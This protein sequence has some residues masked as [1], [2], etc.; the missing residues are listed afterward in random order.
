MGENPTKEVLTMNR[1][2]Q[3]PGRILAIALVIAAIIALALIL[4][5]SGGGGG[6]GGGGY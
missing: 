2:T 1:L 5:Y 6:G 4:A 3:H